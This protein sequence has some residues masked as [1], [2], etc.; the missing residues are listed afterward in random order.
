MSV[1]T[2]GP[3][4]PVHTG[5]PGWAALGRRRKPLTRGIAATDAV[6]L[7]VAATAVLLI[8]PAWG[9]GASAPRGSD[10]LWIFIAISG[11][12][13]A[14]AAVR[15]RDPRLL[16]VGSTEYQR[17][18][19]ATWQTAAILLVGGH[20]AGLSA[21]DR[22]LAWTFVLGL[23]LLALGRAFWRRRIRRLRAT[24]ADVANALVVG[25]ESK[26]RA[27]LGALARHPELGYR[28]IGACMPH[29]ESGRAPD[30]G[31]VRVLGDLENASHAAAEAGAEVVLLTSS[32][33]TG[34]DVVRALGWDLAG[35]GINL[36]LTSEA[37]DTA[38][39]RL[40]VART[41][42]VRLVHVDP[43]RYRGVKY[44][45]KRVGDVIG[46]GLILLV[47]SPLLLGIAVAV[48]ATSPGPVIFRQ[49]RP[50]RNG[51]H[52]T[53]YKFRSMVVGA[54][55]RLDDVIEHV[56]L[57][58]KPVND[59]R[60]TRVGRV[61]R[62]T[63]MDELPQLVNVLL[64]QMSLVGP[65]P[66]TVREVAQYDAVMARR[67]LVTPG[68]TGLWQVSGRSDLPVEE[69]LRY[70]LFYVDNWTLLGDLAILARTAGAVVRGS[71]AS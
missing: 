23:V 44:V 34:P 55:A 38:E 57:Y 36:V 16:A 14:L 48:K 19:W 35:A 70:D 46:A 63:S 2:T 60:V 52:F 62:R 40:V 53:M 3:H 64:G 37:I 54:E 29:D 56:G 69:A 68:M 6:A 45:V 12:W 7:L 32:D 61:L 21:P 31:D 42:G 41:H 71:G 59:P 43:P 15:S 20:L 30:L 26:V 24:G 58:F 51:R 65:R 47:L 10:V 39:R 17:L 67:L 50:G 66:Q 11:S 5:E 18:A 49:P 22:A 9:V 27:V 4:V 25:P 28:A 8:A 1:E 33:H 13:V